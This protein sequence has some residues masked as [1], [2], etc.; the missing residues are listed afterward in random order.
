MVRGSPAVAEPEP[1]CPGSRRTPHRARR[2]PAPFTSHR[3]CARTLLSG[4][5]SITAGRS[6]PW[7]SPAI[8]RTD[9]RAASPSTAVNK[10]PSPD[11]RPV[12]NGAIS[13]TEPTRIPKSCPPVQALHV[14]LRGRCGTRVRKR[15]PQRPENALRSGVSSKPAATVASLRSRACH[16]V[17]SRSAGATFVSRPIHGDGRFTP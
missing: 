6:A 13:E 14:I 1:P 12:C 5:Q 11:P 17:S 15:F 2:R 10:S 9:L 4:S 3:T 16:H 7:M 8:W